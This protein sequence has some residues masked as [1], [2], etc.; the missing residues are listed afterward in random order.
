[1]ERPPVRRVSVP[2]PIGT[3]IDAFRVRVFFCETQTWTRSRDTHVL[4]WRARL[5]LVDLAAN[6]HARTHA[7]RDTHSGRRQDARVKV[8]VKPSLNARTV[9][10]LRCRFNQNIKWVRTITRSGKG[11]PLLR[12][13]KKKEKERERTRR[14][15]LS[16]SLR[17]SSKQPGLCYCYSRMKQLEKKRE[18]ERLGGRPAGFRFRR[19]LHFLRPRAA[20]T[21]S[22][23]TAPCCG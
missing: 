22:T 8:L 20:R 16:F 18:E 6:T 17:S 9:R 15:N 7:R 21:L 4:R 12:K 3:V 2:D 14:R 23:N 13:R 11:R 19:L 1:M 5:V 10:A